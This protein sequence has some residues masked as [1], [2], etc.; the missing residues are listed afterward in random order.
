MMNVPFLDEESCLHYSCYYYSH[1]LSSIVDVGIGYYDTVAVDSD[2][3]KTS[4]TLFYQSTKTN[5]IFIVDG[6]C[7]NVVIESN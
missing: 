3:C 6:W 7:C 4:L 2:N 5:S 1:S